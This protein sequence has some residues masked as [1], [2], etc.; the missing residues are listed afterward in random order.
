MNIFECGGKIPMIVVWCNVV[1]ILDACTDTKL[2]PI[3]FIIGLNMANPVK[4]STTP[5]RTKPP[6]LHK[7]QK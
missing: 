6:H 3:P 7:I 1:E 2:P 4:W 5:L